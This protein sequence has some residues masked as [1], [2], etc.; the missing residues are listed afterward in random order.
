[1][2]RYEDEYVRLEVDV[3]ENRDLSESEGAT[4]RAVTG[5]KHR[6]D[7]VMVHTDRGVLIFDAQPECCDPGYLEEFD[8]DPVELVGSTLVK[9]KHRFAKTEVG[10]AHWYEIETT[11]GDL[12]TRWS[13]S[14]GSSGM[15]SSDVNVLWVPER[16]YRTP[17]TWTLPA[18]TRKAVVELAS[19]AGLDR[20]EFLLGLL[21]EG[22]VES[23]E[24]LYWGQE[25]A[26]HFR[27]HPSEIDAVYLAT[28]TL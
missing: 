3:W 24:E 2:E 19:E 12:W 11:K 16:R 23:A 20:A 1:M 18:E 7:V 21:R 14:S 28:S 8:G 10:K 27:Y 26:V 15:Y 17:F 6:S 5:F 22:G 13:K 9:L 4:I 25:G